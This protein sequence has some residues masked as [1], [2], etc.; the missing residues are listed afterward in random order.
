MAERSTPGLSLNQMER[1][2]GRGRSQ[3]M[4]WPA[5]AA[6]VFVGLTLC[7]TTVLAVARL[8]RKTRADR[9]PDGAAALTARGLA[10]YKAGEWEE[11][12]RAFREVL[13]Q[14]PGNLR[15]LDYLERLELIGRDAE[16]LRRAEE[17]LVA[18][19]PHTASLLASSVAPNSPLFAQ[20]ERVARS[21]R[22][23]LEKAAHAVALKKP[24]EVG[25]PGP[26]IDVTVALGEALALY[27]LGN[28]AEAVARATN[29]AEQAQPEVRDELVRWAQDARRFAQHFQTLPREDASLVQHVP[30]AM[31]AIML[32]ERLSDGH[33]ARDLRTRMTQ[34]L[35][36]HARGLFDRNDVVKGCMYVHDA[37]Q[38]AARGD[39]VEALV[40]RCENE[41]FRRI[42]QARDLERSNPREA[43][44]LYRQV[45]SIASQGSSSYRA[46]QA[47]IGELEWAHQK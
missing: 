21:A 45:L 17:A 22:E 3:T 15:A 43:V 20:S 33:F 28:F 19:E 5:V 35:A 29:L 26:S 24:K 12:E 34:A 37:E 41:A 27:E 16:R 7:A 2:R 46:A 23:Q 13:A 10:A 32:D 36:S 1:S 4:G 40:A 25:A 6:L 11:A 42:A 44:A 31:E 8:P 18:G 14:S 39:A 47:A 30:S 38:F 9:S